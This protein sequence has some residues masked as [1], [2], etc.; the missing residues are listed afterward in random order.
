MLVYIRMC[1][2]MFD[3]DC[4]LGESSEMTDDRRWSCGGAVVAGDGEKSG[5][6]ERRGA[7]VA[8]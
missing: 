8:G 2:S 5:R 3:F 4:V 7:V 6:L 1:I